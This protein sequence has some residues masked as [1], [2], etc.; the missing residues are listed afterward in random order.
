M[1]EIGGGSKNKQ[2][3]ENLRGRDALQLREG[4]L[5]GQSCVIGRGFFALSRRSATGMS[6]SS[7]CSH[8]HFQK[9]ATEQQRNQCT[10]S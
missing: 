1:A 2:Y 3:P 6:S 4:T 5:L 10:G 8:S 9:G 7:G